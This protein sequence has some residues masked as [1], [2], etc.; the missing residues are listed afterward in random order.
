MLLSHAWV[1]FFCDNYC[2]PGRI[3]LQKVS[4]YA[5]FP[6]NPSPKG[7]WNMAFSIQTR[8]ILKVAYFQT[9]VPISTEFCT[10]I[11][12][13]PTTLRGWYRICITNPGWRTAALLKN[14]KI[15]TFRAV[16][17][18]QYSTIILQGCQVSSVYL[19]QFSNV[20][21]MKLPGGLNFRLS[22]SVLH[23][24]LS[25]NRSYALFRPLGIKEIDRRY[26]VGQYF[27]VPKWLWDLRRGVDL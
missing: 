12:R 23:H 14:W 21:C 13:T 3:K 11:Y 19:I 4:I 15:T 7:A 5:Y 8:I 17:F 20:G 18:V 16:L 24:F 22:A 27:S 26:F 10:M 2:I 6:P 9:S 25:L 1:L